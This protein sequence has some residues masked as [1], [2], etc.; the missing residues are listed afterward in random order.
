MAGEGMEKEE[1]WFLLEGV[2]KRKDGYGRGFL[3]CVD[4]IFCAGN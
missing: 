4:D 3:H 1:G 2:K